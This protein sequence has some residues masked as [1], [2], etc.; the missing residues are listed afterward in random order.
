M[1]K[2]KD[3]RLPMETVE[4]IIYDIFE[5]LQYLARKSII[6]R[7]IKTANILFSN[8]G[9]VKIADFGFATYCLG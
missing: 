6:H 4:R 8:S 1:A 9:R 5:G 7:D 3:G 2:A